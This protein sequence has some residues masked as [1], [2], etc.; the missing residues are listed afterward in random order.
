MIIVPF[1]YKSE[2]SEYT[3]KSLFALKESY[4]LARVSGSEILIIQVIEKNSLFYFLSND[5]L[6]EMVEGLSYKLQQIA[7][8]ESIENGVKIN[9]VV[10][11]GRVASEV[12]KIA[13]ENNAK[14]IVVGLNGK[15]PVDKDYI[16]GNTLRLIRN[17]DIPVITVSGKLKE[18]REYNNI[19][20]PLDL[21]KYT[22][23][24]VNKAIEIARIFDSKI[25]VCSYR[26][27]DVSCDVHL[28]KVQN[29]LNRSGIEYNIE[30]VKLN[31]DLVHKHMLKY[32]TDNNIDLCV[33][34]SK[35]KTD[36]IVNF[37]SSVGQQIIKK[38]IIPV[39]TLN[40]KELGFINPY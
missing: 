1:N 2:E 22:I 36:E 7:E 24:K 34:M 11:V 20:L 25:H 14:W 33:V 3:N 10:R 35:E 16:G 8:K 39:M 21:T 37:V 40:P 15:K 17:T 12:E 9:S 38:S 29:L 31:R 13:Q 30:L 27:K 32:I 6:S 4:N 19:F 5:Q 26:G 23:Q 28:K 18:H